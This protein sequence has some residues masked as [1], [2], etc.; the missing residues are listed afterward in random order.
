MKKR[1]L[2]SLIAAF[3]CMVV[4]VA[5]SVSTFAAPYEAKRLACD[6]CHTYNASYGYKSHEYS[7]TEVI[8][9][10]KY[11]RFCGRTVPEGESHTY[12]HWGR[13]LFYVQSLQYCI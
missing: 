11:C 9:A 4:I 3:M 10:G 7:Y 13:I 5:T 8:S 6:N 2:K 12:V 1:V